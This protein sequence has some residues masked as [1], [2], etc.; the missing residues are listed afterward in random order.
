MLTG[1]RLIG[2]DMITTFARAGLRGMSAVVIRFV[3]REGIR[4]LT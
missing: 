4:C 1:R 2:R 3:I